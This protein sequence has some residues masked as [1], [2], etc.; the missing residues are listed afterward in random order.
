MRRLVLAAAIVQT[1]TLIRP[2]QGTLMY[3]R[4]RDLLDR[5]RASVLTAITAGQETA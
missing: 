3:L 4:S 1:V 5:Q 2:A